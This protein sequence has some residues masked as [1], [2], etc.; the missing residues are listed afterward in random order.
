MSPRESNATALSSCVHADGA[1]ERLFEE[2]DSLPEYD[3]C[4]PPRVSNAAALSSCVQ[5][6]GARE[7]RSDE[8]V[9]PWYD[10]YRDTAAPETG[11]VGEEMTSSLCGGGCGGVS[12]S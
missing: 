6:E 2:C 11:D 8:V 4:L 7:Y 12:P 10:V 1:L 5:A 3:A 9:L